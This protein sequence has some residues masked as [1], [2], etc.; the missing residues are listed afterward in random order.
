MMFP[1][2]SGLRTL[3]RLHYVCRASCA[4]ADT[5]LKKTAVE[6]R[7]QMVRVV[8]GGYFEWC[9]LSPGLGSPRAEDSILDPAGVSSSPRSPNHR[10]PR[11]SS[12][13]KGSAGD[14]RRYDGRPCRQGMEPFQGFQV[15]HRRFYSFR[16][17]R[18]D[19]GTGCEGS[20]H[21]PR[22]VR[23]KESLSK[24]VGPH[25]GQYMHPQELVAVMV[26]H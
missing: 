26:H 24:Q 17:G 13:Q 15:R 25:M 2:V 3:R 20:H 22:C 6:R 21:P 9:H 16:E 7:A 14:H 12:P 4:F 18:M 11:P 5:F 23:Q 8:G 10:G 19:A 1:F